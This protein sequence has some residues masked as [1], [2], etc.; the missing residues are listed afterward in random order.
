MLQHHVTAA[1]DVVDVLDELL[2]A[3]VLEQRFE[4]ALAVDQRRATQVEAVEVQQVERVV[5][6]PA[7]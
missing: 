7:L 3:G 6:K 4:D 5:D 1:G 2:A